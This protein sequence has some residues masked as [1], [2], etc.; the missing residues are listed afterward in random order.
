MIID[1]STI[2][3]GRF[4]R[5]DLGP[6]TVSV[7]EGEAYL[8]LGPSRLKPQPS[9]LVSVGP[10]D[11]RTHRGPVMIA[12]SIMPA[13]IIVTKHETKSLKLEP[14]L[15]RLRDGVDLTRATFGLEFLASRRRCLS[16]GRSLASWSASVLGPSE[17]WTFQSL[18]DDVFASRFFQGMRSLVVA[19]KEIKPRNLFSIDSIS[20]DA[21]DGRG[22]QLDLVFRVC[23]VTNL[24]WVM[25]GLP[26]RT[27][28]PESDRRG[29]VDADYS[30]LGHER[31]GRPNPWA[32]YFP[33]AV[34]GRE[35]LVVFREHAVD[36]R[37]AFQILMQSGHSAASKGGTP[38]GLVVACGRREDS[39]DLRKRRGRLDRQ[40]GHDPVW[41]HRLA[42]CFFPSR[43]EQDLVER[44]FASMTPYERDCLHRRISLLCA[45][46]ASSK[47][48]LF[49]KS[50]GRLATFDSKQMAAALREV[51]K[52]MRTS[53]GAAGGACDLTER[54]STV[55][56]LSRMTRRSACCFDSRECGRHLVLGK[57]RGQSRCSRCGATVEGAVRTADSLGPSWTC[58]PRF[59]VR[60]CLIQ[61]LC[62]RGYRT[63]ICH[64]S[65]LQLATDEA[66]LRV[67]IRGASKLLRRG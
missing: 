12:R 66:P 25:L 60:S 11:L 2:R 26:P 57:S 32:H 14:S 62:D 27:T 53:W 55:R 34:A 67:R 17:A 61:N 35:T 31:D 41:G 22:Q 20:V 30:A 38:F 9:E 3:A 19:R 39:A 23:P 4:L 51:R 54:E 52:L 49:D 5:L 18:N 42:Q 36:L 8:R 58:A 63:G 56:L 33:V 44:D 48:N 50:L 6:C 64:L 21:E 59:R 45:G 65:E 46:A 47:A 40:Y 43:A 10:I 1:T 37:N 16:S 7:V 29:V 24:V 13:R 15:C 28:R